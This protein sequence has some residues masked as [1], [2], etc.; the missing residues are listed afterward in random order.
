MISLSIVQDEDAATTGGLLDSCAPGIFA[1]ANEQLGEEGVPSQ[2]IVDEKLAQTV[3]VA[4]IL[5]VGD[6]SARRVTLRK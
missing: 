6:R 5:R 2:L 1:A 3:A 4:V